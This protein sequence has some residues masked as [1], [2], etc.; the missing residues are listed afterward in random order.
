MRVAPWPEPVGTTPE[1]HLVDGVQHLDDGALDNLVLQRG[2][3]ERPQPPVRLRDVRPPRRARPVTPLLHPPEQIL[4]V[5]L[6]LLPAG[7]PRH[8]ICTRRGLRAQSPASPP[9][10]L[11]VD[12][13]QQR[14]ELCLL[15]PYCHLPHTIRRT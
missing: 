10:A 1:V 14:R 15:I 11:Q 13:M 9:Q 6:Q 4:E 8:P 5:R 2:N 12:V 3:T 7:R